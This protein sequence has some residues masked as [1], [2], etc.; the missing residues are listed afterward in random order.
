MRANR[1]SASRT[2][3][4]AVPVAGSVTPSRMAAS[5]VSATGSA[6]P[7]HLPFVEA[8]HQLG[9]VAGTEADV[10]LLAQDVVPA[11]LAGA[12]R[13]RQGEDIGRVDHA[14][15]GAALHGGG[16]DFLEADPAE[17]L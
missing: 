8:R 17:G 14:R 1:P 12:R 2:W 15:G 16:P 9:E 3:P 7:G 6:A 10:E 4:C 11:V 13:A 5:K